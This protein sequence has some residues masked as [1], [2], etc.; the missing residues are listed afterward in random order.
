MRKMSIFIVISLVMVIG[1]IFLRD[2]VK[3]S[4]TEPRV[5]VVTK[6]E[7]PNME[8]WRVVIAGVQAA[9]KELGAHVEVMAPSSETDVEGQI[10]ILNEVLTKKT[11]PQAVVL[12]SADYNRLVPAA[13]ALKAKGIALITIDSG[14]NSPLPETFISTD[15]A[16]AGLKS[17]EA[18]VR[19]TGPEAKIAVINFVQGSATAMDRERGVLE[20][21]AR[22][23]GIQKIGTFYSGSVEENGY[24]ITKKLITVHRDLNGIVGL[25]EP[26]TM[27]AAR[28]IQDMGLAGKVKLIGFDSSID[29]IKMIEKGVIQATVVQ[30]PFNM[31]YLGIKTAVQVIRGDKP[32]ARIDTGSEVITKQNMYSDENQKLLFPFVER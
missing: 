21:L 15:N 20:G 13:E 7:Q 24:N 32:D 16:A 29:E 9:A 31:G 12:A 27:G 8:F 10:H 4:A 5:V 1:F 2:R 28:A 14:L 25:N 3:T 22:Y 6:S 11:A 19:E 17:C 30:K 26:S 23:P 18:L